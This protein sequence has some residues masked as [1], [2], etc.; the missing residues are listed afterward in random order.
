[1]AL[2]AAKIAAQIKNE[3]YARLMNNPLGNGR[4]VPGFKGFN[5]TNA[6]D[7]FRRRT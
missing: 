1:L 5:P 6:L 2:D 4:K 3:N 7:K